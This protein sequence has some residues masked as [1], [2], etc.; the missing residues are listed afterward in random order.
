MPDKERLLLVEGQDDRHFIKQLWDKH[1]TGDGSKPLFYEGTE[2]P[3]NIETL[4]GFE[5]LCENIPT[6]INTSSREVLGILADANSDPADRWAMISCKIKE[7]VELGGE[8]KYLQIDPSEIPETPPST[9]TIINNSKPRIGIWLMP[10][11]VS[12]GELEDFAVGMVPEDDPIWPSSRQY[13]SSIP[14]Q[15]RKFH[16]EKTPKAELFAWLA[17]RKNP[18]RMGAAIGAGDLSLDNEPSNT[19]LTWLTE[20]F[21]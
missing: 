10:C 8:S 7:A 18:G 19:F 13:I 14:Q 1:Y 17:T 6:I 12:P 15:H 3:F 4:E 9:G 5:K 2:R 21:E 11:N 20:L 16:D